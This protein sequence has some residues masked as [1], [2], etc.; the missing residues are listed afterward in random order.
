MVMKK[1]FPAEMPLALCA[2]A[3]A[4]LAVPAARAEL[5]PSDVT[6]TS[7]GPGLFRFSYDIKVLGTSEMHTG[8]Y[9]VIYDVQGFVP[10]SVTAPAG[11]SI[12]WSNVGPVPAQTAPNDDPTL[13]N[14]KWTY[15]GSSIIAPGSSTAI[16]S[17]FSFQ[18][19]FG[20]IGEADF[21]S[22]SHVA[23]D[24]THPFG[25]VVSNVT[26]VDVPAPGDS[27]PPDNPPPDNPPGGGTPNEAPEPAS[28]LLLGLGAPL[29]GL[30]AL[31][32]RLKAARPA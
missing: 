24:S 9:G 15:T 27:P 4:L 28:L 14:I 29:A 3:A 32:R 26:T 30:S 20:L 13:P 6:V 1:S 22:L 5:I 12:S 19:T 23:P 11:W 16:V 25:R 2:L 21:A 7:E 8:D 31:L 18:S 17:G 10:G